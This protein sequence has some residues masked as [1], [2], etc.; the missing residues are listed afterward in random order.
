MLDRFSNSDIRWTIAGFTAL[1]GAVL[2]FWLVEPEFHIPA[3]TSKAEIAAMADEISTDMGYL[4]GE[5]NA[6]VIL[7]RNSNLM[8]GYIRQNGKRAFKQNLD[9]PAFTRFFYAWQITFVEPSEPDEDTDDRLSRLE[10]LSDLSPDEAEDFDLREFFDPSLRLRL[11]LNG[12]LVGFNSSRFQI[13]GFADSLNDISRDSAEAIQELFFSAAERFLEQTAWNSYELERGTF[14]RNESGSDGV[15]T[16]DLR[17]TVIDS[18]VPASIRIVL[19]SEGNLATLR[20]A[21]DFSDPESG[22]IAKIL[23][24][25]LHGLFPVLIV[26]LLIA[27]FFKRQYNRL[28]D[29]SIVKYDALAFGFLFSFVAALQVIT[30]DFQGAIPDFGV[31]LISIGVFLGAGL[32]FSAMAVVVFATAD[33]LCQEAFPRKK[34]SF[35][36]LRQGLVKNKLV[37]KSFSRGIAGG[38]LMVLV[39]TVLYGLTDTAMSS[40]YDESIISV[41][42]V[43]GL[44]AIIHHPVIS[45]VV[46]L[47]VVFL[48][49]LI[50]GAWLKLRGAPQWLMVILLT[51]F[52]GQIYIFGPEAG[53][54]YITYLLRFAIV[55]TPVLIFLRYD[56]VSSIITF[57]IFALVMLGMQILISPV[58]SDLFFILVI[59]AL[60]AG[61][62]LVAYVGL[63]STVDYNELPDMEPE[64]IKRLAREQRIEKEFELAREVHDSFLA[65]ARPNVAGYDISSSCKTAYEVGG[66]YYDFITLNEHKTLIVIADVSGK[67]V[68]AAFYMTLIKGYLQ[69]VSE[70]TD[71]VAEI[72]KTV[73]RLFYANS[74]RGTFITALAGVLDTQTNRFTFVRAGH[75]PLYLLGESQRGLLVYQPKGFALGMARP[76]VFNANLETSRIEIKES[77][78]LI[79]FT[80]GYPESFNL[81]RQQLGEKRLQK[82]ILASY[83]QSSSSAQLLDGIRKRVA[84]FVSG[85][86][87]HDDMTMIVISRGSLLR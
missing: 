63:N 66:D 55:L 85:A 81:N 12:E 4:L 67:G 48:F 37:G 29:L 16:T 50:P 65:S 13:P 27:Q 73:N 76:E 46:A 15:F 47:V 7:E 9:N 53:S 31:I 78:P 74:P 45:L 64:Y 70:Q 75:D 14:T 34:Y 41:S 42:S 26:L 40:F 30:E 71:D 10:R 54:P 49:M 23:S 17:F 44:A 2:L 62:L 68:K 19:N 39:F 51:L 33:S 8:Q 79:L 22:Y 1:L 20:L 60:M 58:T 43:R 28:I 83:E 69:S 82:I 24:G 87:Q 6:R 52:S 25:I 59:A 80:D 38:F 18:P 3:E 11:D 32:L 77:K 21:P 57:V 61:L 72:I 35:A 86:R 84:S 36:L 5:E 56:I